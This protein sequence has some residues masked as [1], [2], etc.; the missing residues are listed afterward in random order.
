MS[1]VWTDTTNLGRQGNS[2]IQVKTQKKK[3]KVLSPLNTSG[4]HKSILCMIF[5]MYAA[6]IQKLHYAGQESKKTLFAVDGFD[7]LV[8]LTKLKVIKPGKNW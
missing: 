1:A 6:T 8:T 2:N 3:K 5:V 7:K 4:S